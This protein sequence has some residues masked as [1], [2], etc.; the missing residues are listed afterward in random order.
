MTIVFFSGIAAMSKQYTEPAFKLVDGLGVLF[1]L[2][3]RYLSASADWLRRHHDRFD[4][5]QTE[6]MFDSGAFTAW[7]AGHPPLKA[8]KLARRYERA[9][10]WCE[11]KLKAAW[12]ISLDVLP[13]TRNRDATQEEVASAIRQSDRNHAE[14]ARALPG[15][16]LPVFHRGE[17]LARLREVQ[18]M[19]PGYVC[20]S[21]LV[22]TEEPARIKWSLRAA[23]HLKQRNP[24]T[25]IHGLATTGEEIMRVVDW[26]SV[27]S[28]A[29]IFIAAMGEILVEHDGRLLRIPIG[30]HNGSRRHF[31]AIE[32]ERLRARVEQLV[33]ERGFDLDRM[34]DD[35]TARQLFNLQTMAEWSRGP[36]TR[37]PHDDFRMSLSVR[38]KQGQSTPATRRTGADASVHERQRRLGQRVEP[39]GRPH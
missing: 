14:L 27:D 16:I 38:A 20:L 15:R 21:P 4:L 3:K 23:A 29:W 37:K 31:D 13:G 8:S 26:R 33:A 11:G 12:F 32:D 34:R 39:G 24:R 28:A 22:G 2:H 18:D 25:E 36:C 9:A 5:S 19:N 7:Q 1:S 35:A 6:A 30:R 17:R 10:R